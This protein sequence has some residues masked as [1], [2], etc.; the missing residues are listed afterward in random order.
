[1][2]IGEIKTDLEGKIKPLKEIIKIKT[3]VLDDYKKL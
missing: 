3:Q 1:V 2:A